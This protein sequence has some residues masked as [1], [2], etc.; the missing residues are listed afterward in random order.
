MHLV[1]NLERE[2][3]P[4][5]SVCILFEIERESGYGQC[6]SCSKSRERAGMVSVHLVRNREREREPVG[7]VCILFKIERERERERERESG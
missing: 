4:V 5:G 1:R 2:R 6:A 7:S 3:E